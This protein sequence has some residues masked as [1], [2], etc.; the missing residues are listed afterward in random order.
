MK[1]LI[2]SLLFFF[3]FTHLYSQ[4]ELIWS[5]SYE[6]NLTYFFQEQPTIIPNGKDIQVIGQSNITSDKQSL[7]SVHYNY[8][9]DI[10]SFSHY[11]LDSVSKNKVVDY[12]FDKDKN[13][14]ILHRDYLEYYKSKIVL[15]KYTENGTLLW[16]RQ[17]KC[18]ADTSFTAT[19]LCILNDT[20]ILITAHVETAYPVNSNWCILP[21]C[22]PA[23]YIFNANG[24]ELWEKHFDKNTEIE[25]F[26]TAVTSTGNTAAVLA[27]SNISYLRL[28]VIDINRATTTIKN[29]TEDN[30]INNLQF[31][32]DSNLLITS[33]TDYKLAKL[34]LDGQLIWT[35]Y[36]GTN[37]PT[38]V[39]SDRIVFLLQDD[40]GNMYVTGNLAGKGY[41]TDKYTN[42]DIL[43]VKYDKDGKKIWENIYKFGLNNFEMGSTI[44]LKN[45]YIYVGGESQRAGI[46]TDYDYIVLK[47]DASTGTS[48]GTYR[49]NSS[50]NGK[51]VVSSINVLDNG[52]ICI[53]GLSQA[54]TTYNWL[55]QLISEIK[56]SMTNILPDNVMDIYPNPVPKN[57]AFTVKNSGFKNYSIS[58]MCGETIKNGQLTGTSNSTIEFADIQ[59]GI[60]F[61]TL[62][63][64]NERT[65][66]KI[67][68]K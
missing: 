44:I 35:A 25:H 8:T 64:G 51:D 56:T 50:T 36:Y 2:N 31:T 40:N 24:K 15:Q 9:G 54:D 19:G 10:M 28:V 43:T 30:V 52:Q 47:I 45:N 5:K 17:I 59:S 49:F 37:L 58:N 53:T 1:K 68:F 27:Y 29:I 60:Y 48:A 23:I 32:N 22:N 62:S 14:Y 21:S 12:K 20:S 26:A 18:N 66:K 13:L 67:I 46:S 7:L 61:I 34:N 39:T 57:N 42:G 65:V 6:T 16:V 63:N 55:T 33:A 11:G 4:D 41:D 3:C 38:Y